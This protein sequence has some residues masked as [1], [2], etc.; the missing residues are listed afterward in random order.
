MALRL[1]EA[2]KQWVDLGTQH[3][4]CLIRPESC[5]PEGAAVAFW[6]YIHYCAYNRGIVSS[7][8]AW[9]QKKTGFRIYCVNWHLIRYTARLLV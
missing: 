6:M 1:L 7:T 3:Q 8:L 2:R 5:G 9:T 4:A